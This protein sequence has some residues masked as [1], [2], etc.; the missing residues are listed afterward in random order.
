MATEPR[1]E[2]DVFYT[3]PQDGSGEPDRVPMQFRQTP[4]LPANPDRDKQSSGLADGK[5]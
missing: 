5:R 3:H 2:R 1:H 4:H